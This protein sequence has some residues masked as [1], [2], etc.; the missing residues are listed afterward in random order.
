MVKECLQC[1][2]ANHNHNPNPASEPL[3]ILLYHKAH[4]KSYPWITAVPSQMETTCW[5]F[6]INDFVRN[7]EVDAK[8]KEEMK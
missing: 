6:A 2:A 5:S 7:P 8:R 3:Q 1:Q 4:G